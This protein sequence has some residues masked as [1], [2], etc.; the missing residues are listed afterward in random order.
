MHFTVL[1][2]ILLSENAGQDCKLPASLPLNTLVAAMRRSRNGDK[3]LLDTLDSTIVNEQVQFENNVESIVLEQLYPYWANIEDT[4]YLEFND[5]TEQCKEEYA[6]GGED[7][8]QLVNGQWVSVYDSR[9]SDTYEVF[10]GKIYKRAFGPLHH[11]KR[12]KKAKRMKLANIPFRV[13]YSDYRE[14]AEE[15]WGFKR[16]EGADAY[17]FYTNPNTEFDWFQIGGR[18]PDRFLVK[19]DCRDV[20]SGDLSFFLRDEPAEAAPDGYCWVTGAR[21]KDIAWDLMKELFIQRERETFLSCEKW[22]QSGKLPSDRHDL[23]ITEKGIT[24]WG[25]LIYDKGQTLEEHLR[26]KALSEEY[27]YPLTTYAVLDDGVWNDLYEMKCVS[28]DNGNGNNQL[29]HQ[30][31]E[32]YI[33]SLPEEAMLVS[34]D[35]HI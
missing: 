31:V 2:S 32:K 29:W 24:S 8:V 4:A 20:F 9:F 3:A 28:E 15:Y 22:Y 5:C 34:L 6:T 26:S 14:Y 21:K 12:T 1:T 25:K 11:R 13:Q 35:C 27:R 19:A 18:W 30:V 10:E 23:S 7:K 33:A 16:K 17:G